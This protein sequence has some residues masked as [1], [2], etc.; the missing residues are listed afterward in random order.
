[1]GRAEGR[2]GAA[3]RAGRGAARGT[4]KFERVCTC[5]RLISRISFS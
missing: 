1:M 4:S 5:E 3:E 2:A